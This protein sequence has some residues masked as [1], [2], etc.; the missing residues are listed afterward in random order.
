MIWAASKMI[1]G[2]GIVI[3]LLFFLTRAL[4]RTNLGRGEGPSDS[5]IRLLA[6][7]S[8]APQKYISLVEIGGDIFALGI[9]ENQISLLTKIE[10]REFAEKMRTYR[11]VAS[12]PLSILQHIS[13]RGFIKSS[14]GK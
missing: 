10:N 3:V 14:H 4:K 9:A 1:F 7:Q 8:I 6:T 11:S 13:K 5:G 12:E 2:L